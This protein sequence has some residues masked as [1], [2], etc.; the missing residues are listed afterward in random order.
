MPSTLILW[1]VALIVMLT[2]N[3]AVSWY[4][5]RLETLTTTQ[6]IVQTIVVWLV[7]FVGAFIIYIFHRTDAEPIKPYK[8]T[9]GPFESIDG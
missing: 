8:P 3:S 7:P 6:K 4:V 9:E 1:V 5:S 2:L